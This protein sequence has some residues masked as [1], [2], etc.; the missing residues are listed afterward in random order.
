MTNYVLSVCG[1]HDASFLI[2]SKILTTIRSFN[3]VLSSVS[4]VTLKNE[5]SVKR[6]EHISLALF[7]R[8]SAVRYRDTVLMLVIFSS[9]V[10]DRNYTILLH[11]LF[12]F[13]Q[14][15]STETEDV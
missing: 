11:A 8:I 15:L 4:A 13:T 12:Y 6:R 14:C 7:V 1:V 9:N 10:E 3:V 5:I 2:D